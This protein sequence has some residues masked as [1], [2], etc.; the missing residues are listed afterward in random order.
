MLHLSYSPYISPPLKLSKRGIFIL[1][2]LSL[3]SYLPFI[4]QSCF[5][6]YVSETAFTKI[7]NDFLAL[8][9]KG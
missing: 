1:I 8:K 6:Y 7:N 4:P 5:S 3:F 9:S 2:S